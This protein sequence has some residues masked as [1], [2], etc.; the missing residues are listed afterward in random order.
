MR[1]FCV[2]VRNDNFV[3]DNHKFTTIE[4]Q[5]IGRKVILLHMQIIR[6]ELLLD[7]GHFRQPY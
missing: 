1:S 7:C 2:T 4:R 5:K 3:I 6:E